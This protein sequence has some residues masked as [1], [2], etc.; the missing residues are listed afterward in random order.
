MFILT[1]GFC[2]G[3]DFTC[4]AQNGKGIS[5]MKLWY[6]KPADKW[7]EALPVGNGRLGAMVFGDPHEEVIQLNENT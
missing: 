5:D 1:L 2:I 4:H 3:G 6:D 7:V